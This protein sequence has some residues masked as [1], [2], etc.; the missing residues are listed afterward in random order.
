M[1]IY[2]KLLVAFAA[3]SLPIAVVSIVIVTQ[4]R[5][6]IANIGAFQNRPLYMAQALGLQALAA[7]EDSF[8]YVVSGQEREKAAFLKWAQD[9]RE[10][11]NEFERLNELEDPKAAIERGPQQ[12]IL[13]N[14]IAVVQNATLMF[15]EYE[16]KG[17]ISDSIFNHYELAVNQLQA[18]FAKLIQHKKDDVNE[19]QDEAIQIIKRNEL[20]LIFLAVASLISAIAAGFFMGRTLCNPILELKHVG[21]QMACG[22]FD[23]RIT[24]ESLK[25]E[26]GELARSMSRMAQ[27][28]KKHDAEIR[29]NLQGMTALHEIAVATASTLDV[30]E[31]LDILLRRIA[32]ILPYSAV[33]IKLVDHQS[34]ELRPAACWNL[35]EKDWKAAMEKTGHHGLSTL[36]LEKKAPL[37]VLN[38]QTEERT[39]TIELFRKEGLISYL[40]LPLIAKGEMVGVLSI[41]TKYPHQFT[42]DEIHFFLT[43]ASQ[44]AIAI[45]NSQL[46]E[47]TK[48]QA[49]ELEQANHQLHKQESIQKLLKEINEDITM[50][51]IEPLLKKVT[52]KVREA[53]SVDIS[54]VRLFSQATSRL[55]AAAGVKGAQ[56]QWGAKKGTGGRRRAWFFNERKPL[57]IPDIHKAPD[58]FPPLGNLH[59][60]GMRGYLGVP[61]LSRGGQVVGALRA[62]SY[63]PRFFSEEEIALL[64]QLANGVGIAVESA[65]LVEKIRAQ[66]DELE[67]LNKKQAD[68]TAMIAHDLRSPMQNVIGVVTMMEDGVFG[69]VT[70]EQKKWLNKVITTSHGLVNLVSDFLDFSK[71]EAGHV[72][73]VKEDF[74]LQQLI[75]ETVESHLPAAQERALLLSHQANPSLRPICA[76]PRRLG[77]VLNNLL[78]NAIKFTPQGGCVE[79]GAR[80]Q[81]D[82]SV[83]V[84]VKDSG[85]G[86]PAVEIDGLFKKYGQTRTGR[87]SQHKG[88]GLG[89]VICKTIVEA[90]GGKIWVESEEGKGTTF[91]FS[92]PN[93][94][95]TDFSITT[96]ATS[97]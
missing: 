6:E 92:L 33:T 87:Q 34:R 86:I 69:A 70:D 95:V 72:D 44:A 78:S 8:A 48:T 39:C 64:Q 73:L 55:L 50:L 90:H 52:D 17:K 77:Q 62:L 25:D 91:S 10:R 22:N 65:R 75:Q 93:P 63:S 57:H 3:V 43:L 68:F 53:F 61:V 56:D 80:R 49:G 31:V 30:T 85:V 83:R 76:D 11:M 58:F 27:D 35:N 54:D 37:T 59:D 36:V 38:L 94:V 21:E 84:D 20:I 41:F 23:V 2:Q 26:I 96:Q 67:K 19:A 9:F 45:C 47:Q 28:L 97:A 24:S 46:Y 40:G 1:K 15:D 51:E 81:E 29:R 12:E 79:V 42:K 4:T 89:L 60:Y 82:K 14:Q 18:N 88:T 16:S 13:L 7:V 32:L 74:D 71:I 66:A 5:H